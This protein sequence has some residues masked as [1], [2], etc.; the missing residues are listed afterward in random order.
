MVKYG[1][2]RPC[3]RCD[4]LS[5][6]GGTDFCLGRLPYMQQACCGHG[7]PE[8]A[9]FIFHNGVEVC[10]AD[11]IKLRECW[12]HNYV[13]PRLVIEV[14]LQVLNVEATYRL[15]QLHTAGALSTDTLARIGGLICRKAVD[16]AP[17]CGILEVCR[18]SND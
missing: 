10:G 6:E 8:E 13:T 14:F 11:A 9:Y 7:L 15:C 16:I 1:K 5:E 18:G 3:T 4:N 17:I 2:E 12:T